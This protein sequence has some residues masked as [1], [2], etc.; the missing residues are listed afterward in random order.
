MDSRLPLGAEVLAAYLGVYS[1]A[2]SDPEPSGAVGIGGGGA[3]GGCN[4]LIRA[5]AV[6]APAE[7]REYILKKR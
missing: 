6:A 5:A 1:T 3:F 4:H 7:E 2:G